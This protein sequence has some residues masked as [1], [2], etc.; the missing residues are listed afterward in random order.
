MGDNFRFNVFGKE[1]AGLAGTAIAGPSGHNRRGQLLDLNLDEHD[2]VNFLML[3]L[4]RFK[5]KEIRFSKFQ[6]NKR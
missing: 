4:Y 3:I 1:E 5:V 2:L 6:D